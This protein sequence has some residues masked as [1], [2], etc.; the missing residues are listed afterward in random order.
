MNV[1]RTFGP[2]PT[3]NPA[4]VMAIGFFDGVHL[5]HQSVIETCR[6]QAAGL[7]AEPWV[8][9]FDPHPLQLLQ[10]ANAPR[11]I[12]HLDVK[13][14]ILS[15]LSIRGVMVVPFTREFSQLTPD[16]FLRELN[17]HLPGLKGIV[18]GQN[19]RFGRNAGGDTAMLRQRAHDLPFQVTIAASRETAGGDL[20]SSSR[21]RETIARGHLDEVSKMLGRNHRLHGKV[22]DGLKRGRKLGFPTANLDL[23]GYALPPPGIYAARVH[24]NHQPA[25]A[26][27]VYLPA[28]QDTQNGLLEV[29]LIDFS[30]NLYGETLT[31]EFMQR[32]RGDDLRFTNESDL[33]HQIASDVDRIR[34]MLKNYGIASHQN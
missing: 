12:T 17:S 4:V 23:T 31:V 14:N 28:N 3:K 5:G 32:I 11:L 9:T 7:G 8:M 16:D 25:Y 15:G 33:I 29:H 27:A 19:W 1:I 6:R 26:G 34:N 22:V 30:G 21:I 20:I 10:P 13:L 24:R 18:V 2:I